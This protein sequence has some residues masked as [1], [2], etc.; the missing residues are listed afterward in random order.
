[1]SQASALTQ[2]MKIVLLLSLVACA[3]AGLEFWFG[4]T[5]ENIAK[6]AAGEM[7]PYR[8]FNEWV[9]SYVFSESFIKSVMDSRGH[10]GGYYLLCYLRDLIAGTIVYWGTAGLWHLMIYSLYGKEIFESKGRP[11]PETSLIRDQQ[12]LAQSG[13]FLYAALPIFSEFSAEVQQKSVN[14]SNARYSEYL[15]T[16]GKKMVQL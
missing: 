15:E 2:S 14:L 13:L 6:T 4:N 5:A 8:D 10:K 7:N 16:F 9:N 12:V 11:Y 1:M 3:S